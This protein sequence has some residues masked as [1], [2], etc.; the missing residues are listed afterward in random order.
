MNNLIKRYEY[1]IYV[2]FCITSICNAKC[3]HCSSKVVK[4]KDISTD[5]IIR[6]LYDLK[7]CGVF[8][9]A[10][11]GGE[12]LL[13]PDF[14]KILYTASKLEF[15]IGVGTNGTNINEES[16]C[17]LKK[18]H[19]SRVQISLDGSNPKTHDSFRGS[20]GMFHNSIQAIEMLVENGIRTN[21]CMT[22]TRLNYMELADVIDLAFNMGASGFN[23]SQFVPITQDMDYLDL[24]N[25]DWKEVLEIW[26]KKK[27]LYGEKMSFTSHESQLILVDNEYEKIKGFIGCQAGNGNACILADGTVTPCVMLYIPIG[28][29]KEDP[30]DEIW[31]NSNLVK[32]LANRKLLEGRCKNCENI[33]KC[34][35]C[36]AVAY[37]KTK[38]VFG[39]DL[40]CW[41]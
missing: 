22:P 9:I 40:R 13:H 8:N 15:S 2:T 23:L 24:S 31:K 26:Y 4:S 32:K 25:D 19:V 30:F 35:G 6:T 17:L 10:I 27:K 28:N 3:K 12:P 41:K 5:I 38:N 1:P 7:K 34:G 16:I 29:I 14:E 39:S 18:Y 37:A 33:L 11:S 36:R 21:I 20:S